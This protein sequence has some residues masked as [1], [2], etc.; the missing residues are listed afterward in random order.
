MD[1][2][3]PACTVMSISAGGCGDGQLRAHQETP[4]AAPLPGRVHRDEPS[5]LSGPGPAAAP[6]VRSLLSSPP[7]GAAPTGRPSPGLQRSVVSHRHLVALQRSVGNQAVRRLLQRDATPAAPATTAAVDKAVKSGDPMDIAA[8]T[9]YSPVSEPDRVRF[10]GILLG[11]SS[12]AISGGHIINIWRSF[13]DDQ[14][15]N[16][17]VAHRDLWD[18]SVSRFGG[19]PFV[20]LPPGLVTQIKGEYE[21][22]VRQMA[23][24][25]LK[26]NESYVDNRMQVM[27]F[28]AGAAQPISPGAMATLRHNMQ[29]LAWDIWSLRQSQK[30]L[31][32]TP[33][34]HDRPHPTRLPLLLSLFL[35]GDPNEGLILFNP[36]QQ[37]RDDLLPLWGE[38]KQEWDLA[39]AAMSKTAGSYPEILRVA[40]RGR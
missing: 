32:S 19:D 7:P 25:T 28:K 37:P 10:I 3:E 29:N 30:K 22:A 11:E 15:Q 16:V 24:E 21:T 18:R 34:G 38:L 39:Q 6:P 9:D 2:Q 17:M 13:P 23:T 26:Q 1:P 20:V 36:R 8:I 40:G 27:G 14:F 4:E 5:D 33:I 31:E 35:S 12:E